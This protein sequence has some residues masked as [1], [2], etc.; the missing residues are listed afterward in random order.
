M[1]RKF[2][3]IGS[4]AAIYLLWGST[5]FAIALA[6][7]S[8]PPFLLMGI[9]SLCGGLILVALCGRKIIQHSRRTWL[10]AGLSGL[11]FCVGCHGVLAFAQQTVPSGVA[12][13]VL[14]TIPLWIVLLDFLL[15]QK[16]RP[17]PLTMM[18]LVPGFGGVAVVAWQNIG[19]NGVSILSILWL[20]GAAL[21]WSAGTVWSRRTASDGSSTLIS[22]MQLVI[23][24]AVLLAISSVTGEA[25]QFSP[26]A[27]S[28]TSLGA[29]TY[30]VV[31]GS[32]IGFATY[33]WLLGNVAT[34]L[35]STYTFVNP[36]V[37]I[38]LGT[39]FLRETFSTAMIF[40]TGLVLASIIVMWRSEHATASGPR[41]ELAH[42]AG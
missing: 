2:L 20:L 9:R 21:S 4:F 39:I 22:G 6:L 15:P 33:H 29:V 37:A 17:A 32:V 8:F 26:Q 35:V 19:E 36:V 38:L 3:I 12:A 7:K 14:A 18:A 30:L 31:A 5:Y 10:N 1:V 27:V 13:I 23:G 24:G 34:P 42:R 40:G 28:A 25:K 11:M 16:I 41:K